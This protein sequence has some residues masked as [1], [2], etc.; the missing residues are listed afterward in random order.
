MALV[1]G[2]DIGARSIGWALLEKEG[3]NWRRIVRAG[4]RV[5][6]A[7]TEGDIESGRDESR[8][9]NRRTKRLMRRQIRRRRQRA[10]TLYRALAQAGFLPEIVPSPGSPMSLLIQQQINALDGQF[11]AR[12]ASEAALH[13]LPYLLRAR[14]LDHPLEPFELGR[15]LYHLGQ[16]RGFRSNRKAESRK[17]GA[18]DDSKAK[19]EKGKVYEGIDALRTLIEQAGARTLGEYFSRIDPAEQRIRGRYTHR[20]MYEQEFEAIWSAQR[21]HHAVLSQELK[22]CLWNILFMQRPLR[23][24]EDLVGE[25]SW[26][27]GEKRAPVWSLEFQRYRLLAAL[28]HLRV[29][30][31]RSAPRPLSNTE[32]STLLARL[33]TTDK[34]SIAQAKRL[35]GLSRSAEFTVEE[36]GEKNLPGNKVAAQFVSILGD[37]WSALS[38]EKQQ[39]LVAEVASAGSDE[40]LES[41][42]QEKWGF[43]EETSRRIA[44]EVVLP[45]GYAMLS[46]KALRAIMPFLEQ[47]LSVQ[48]ARQAAGIPLERQVPVHPLLPPLADSGVAVFNPAVKR[49]LTELRK[50]VNAVVRHYG[51]PD[52]IHIETA[53][54]LRKSRDERLKDSKRMR[55]RER[56]RDKIRDQIHREVGIPLEQISREDILKGLLWLECDGKCPYCGQSLGGFASLFGG[57]SPAQIEHII[58]FSRSLDNSFVNLTLA[59]VSDNAE[60]GNRTPW[61]AYGSDPGMWEQILQRV[62]TFKGAYAKAKLNRFKMDKDAVEKLIAEFHS[63]HLNDT[64]AAA[65]AAA[66]Y[67]SL[68]YGGEIVDEKRKILKPTGQVTAYLR[69]VWDLNGLIPSIHREA[70]GEEEPEDGKA[71]R[72]SRDDHRHHAIDAVAVALCDQKT[73][74]LL[75]EANR[76]A[77]AARRRLFA[78]VPPPWVGFKEELRDV[79]KS[80][81][82]SFRPDHRVTGALHKET[83][84]TRV[85]QSEAGGDAVRV[86]VPVH[87]LSAKEVQNIA[88]TA[89]RSAVMEKLSQV[90]ND[91]KKL[92]NNWPCLPNRNGN[93]VPIK[94]VRVNLNR[95]VVKVGSGFRERWAEP[96]ETHHIEIYE[97]QE[98]GRTVWTG[99]VVSMREAIRRAARGEP[100]VRRNGGPNARFLFSLAKE[101]TVRLGGE[102]AGIWV[103]KKIRSNTQIMLVPQHDARPEKGREGSRTQFAPA[104]GGLVRYYAEKVAALP[105]GDVVLCHD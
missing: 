21:P 20:S 61:E 99:D 2:L 63:R 10:R 70:R 51:K 102:K 5:F 68:L 93:P 100:V 18:E 26:L 27:P 35:L 37:Q 67:L 55:D 13:K 92:E 57:N 43:D 87:T 91:P 73:I 23:D 32:R 44:R 50:V 71:I 103:V 38:S 60:K 62:A 14:A 104:A 95:A 29:T 46:L 56:E 80:M 28:N 19:E 97:V 16:R 1:L 41:A 8:G 85:G 34:L 36:G 89:V 54:E 78:P 72:K 76:G 98:N 39:A 45:S 75:S 105:I 47:G 64:R 15:V 30:D 11:R 94:R 31:N 58:P 7:G 59:H 17:V 40:D 33:E 3:D 88:D 53:R 66:R 81:N 82:I 79:L 4:V 49:T 90:G 6:E 24:T 77:A 22:D 52:E 9:A 12:H 84:Y 65:V 96:S 42:L 86:R 48:E 74:Q 101:D 69:D 83:F 25:C